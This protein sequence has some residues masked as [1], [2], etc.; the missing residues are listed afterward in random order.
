MKTQEET[1]MTNT[2]N[3]ISWLF[4]INVFAA[5]LLNLFWGNDPY[6]GVMLL[7]FTFVYIPPANAILRKKFGIHIPAII[8]I[9][10]V[11]FIIVAVLGVG[12]FF[13]KIDP[14]VKD[15]SA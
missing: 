10:L 5:G 15:L 3:I 14:M 13:N 6:F 1:I 7:V 11:I 2:S 12:E 8:K 4:G 9:L